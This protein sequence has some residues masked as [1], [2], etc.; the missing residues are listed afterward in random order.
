M[1]K[2]TDEWYEAEFDRLIQQASDAIGG[3][4]KG[5]PVANVNYFPKFVGARRGY[6]KMF[7]HRGLKGDDPKVET[8]YTFEP[9][10]IVGW[11]HNDMMFMHTYNLKAIKAFVKAVRALFTKGE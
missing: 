3:D 11:V 6:I 2:R 9:C 5:R 1:P 10:V 7:H 8:G 4:H